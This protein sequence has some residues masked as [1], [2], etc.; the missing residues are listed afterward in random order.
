MKTSAYAALLLVAGT[1]FAAGAPDIQRVNGRI[2]IA[3][4]ETAGD[5]ST[6]N[7]AIHIGDRAVIGSVR[8]V[9]GQIALGA[10]ASAQSLQT[11]NGAIAIG[12]GAHV[13]GRATTVNG[14]ID[15]SPSADVAGPLS[16]VNGKITV[17]TAHVGGGI[18]TVSGDIDIEGQ[19]RIDGGIL[20]RQACCWNQVLNFFGV[21]YKEPTVI[22]GPGATVQ[23]PLT[24]ERDVHLY[25]SDGAHIGPVTGTKTIVYSGQGPHT[26]P[27]MADERTFDKHFLNVPPGGKLTVDSDV[28]SIV[29]VGHHEGREIVVHS[30]MSGSEDFISRLDIKAVQG[31]GGVSVTGRLEHDSWLLRW[32]ELGRHTV[33]YTV[34][35]PSDYPVDLHTS[36]GSLDVRNLDASLRG[37]TSGGSVTVREV[38]G[39]IYVRTSGG[40]IDAAELSGPTQLRTSGGGIEVTDC[41]G[42]LDVRTS[43]GGIRLEG[44]DGKVR[45]V[46]A[47]GRVEAEI[48]ANRGVLLATS[49]GGIVLFLPADVHGS[50]D[51]HTSGGRVEAEIPLSTT[52]IASRSELRGDINGGGEPIYLRTSGGSI[53]V[54]PTD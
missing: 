52:E 42:D 53:H 2:D 14:A 10:T 29:I 17:A 37:T 22:I 27:A 50:I 18:T 1:A 25:V 8:T 20:I 44:I 16:N 28:G 41:A 35:V 12:S 48:R 49:G 19:S 3:D 21:P 40:R 54:G 38:H 36:G 9:N 32:F 26:T 34:D 4:S 6:V 7:G 51:A 31:S 47:G 23:G 30:E 5:V 46:T 45:A 43:G 39:S 15:L 11:V 33:L 24:F 13:A